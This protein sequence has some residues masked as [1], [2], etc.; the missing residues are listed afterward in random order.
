[1]VELGQQRIDQRH[2][3]LL[4]DRSDCLSINDYEP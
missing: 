4:V 1:M 3:F 2:G